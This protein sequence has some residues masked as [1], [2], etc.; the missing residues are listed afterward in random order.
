MVDTFI[1]LSGFVRCLRQNVTDPEVSSRA[2]GSYWIDKSWIDERYRLYGW[3]QI[4]VFQV[5]SSAYNSK[6]GTMVYFPRI[7]VD[8]FA[9]GETQKNSLSD[10]VKRVVLRTRRESL[11]RSGIGMD[12]LD[13]ETDSIEDERVPLKAYRKSLL[14]TS[15]IYSTGV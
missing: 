6:S 13:G 15:L 14:F 10:T 1:A 5:G 12:G 2:S 11:S 8:I 4:S 3:P 7:Q 9:S